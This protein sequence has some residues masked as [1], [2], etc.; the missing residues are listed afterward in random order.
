MRFRLNKIAVVADI[1][2]AYVQLELNSCDRDVTRFLWLKDVD[3]P[4]SDDN[5]Q[6][7]RFR[8][9]IW[10]IICSAFLLAST[11]YLH[12][13]SY[14]NEISKDVANNLYVDNLVSGVVSVE[15]GVTYYNTVKRI[16]NEASMNMCKWSSNSKNLMELMKPEDRCNDKS[17]KILGVMWNTDT[18]V[19]RLTYLKDNIME[20]KLS[21]RVMLKIIASVYDPLGF[22]APVMIK[23]KVLL[24]EMWRRGIEWDD[25]IPEDIRLKWNKISVDLRSLQ[26]IALPR[27]IDFGDGKGVRR[28]ELITFADASK[29]AYSAAVYLKI[30][31]GQNIDVNVVFAKSRLAPVK[32]ISIP[33]LELLAVLIGCRASVFVAKELK[34]GNIR[35]TIMTDSRCVIE[36]YRSEKELKRFVRDKIR[37][38]RSFELRIGYVKSE[39]NPADIASRGESVKNLMQNK[40]WWNG[41]RWLVED[42]ESYYSRSYEVPEDIRDAVINE[43]RGSNILHEVGLISELCENSSSPFGINENKFSSY[44]TLIRVTSWCERFLSNIR[45]GK[46]QGCLK[47]SEILKSKVMWIKYIQ[48]RCFSDIIRDIKT[49]KRNSIVN[50]LGLGVDKDGI[51]RCFGRFDSKENAPKLLPKSCH[52]TNLIIERNHK[53]MLHAGVSQTLSETRNEHWVIHGRSAVRKVIRNCL[54]CI[55]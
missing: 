3:S 54:V 21:K 7:Y 55:R 2:K 45:R 27:C 32:E 20:D 4:V 33:R 28:Y 14:K 11:I 34:L 53:R 44:S 51:L 26:N 12:L 16:F 52:F 50:S 17:I 30:V 25:D 49:N 40:L 23:F 8:R 5:L 42:D 6:E 1:E 15:D 43:E 48:S 31:N 36:W 9:V 24:Q 37:E 41:P 13:R 38:I 19:L 10:G 18:D 22:L 47:A 29:I 35:Q 39:E 46:V